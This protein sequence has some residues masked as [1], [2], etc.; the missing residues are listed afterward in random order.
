MLIEKPYPPAET[1]E[2]ATANS[3]AARIAT[4]F[5]FMLVPPE[6]ADLEPAWVGDP[7]H[8]SH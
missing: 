1:G 8:P 6:L 5:V 2:M 4:R 7:F 3:A